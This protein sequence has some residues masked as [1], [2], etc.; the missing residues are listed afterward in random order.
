MDCSH[1]GTA[2]KNAQKYIKS[3]YSNLSM[4]K[5]LNYWKN[6]YSKTGSVWQLGEESL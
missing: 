6:D 2:I 3:I 4:Y 1:D 5:L